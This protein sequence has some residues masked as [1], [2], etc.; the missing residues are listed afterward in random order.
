MPTT[1]FVPSHCIMPACY[2]EVRVCGRIEGL[3]QDNRKRPQ[4]VTGLQN[5][6]KWQKQKDAFVLHVNDGHYNDYT[7][8]LENWHLPVPVCVLPQDKQ[9]RTKPKKKKSQ[10][11][12]QCT[13]LSFSFTQG[14]F[15][16]KRS[17][18]AKAQFQ[19]KMSILSSVTEEDTPVNY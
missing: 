7:T 2:L 11:A 10:L 19:V 6:V 4:S 8:L 16:Y 18:G 13:P 12:L 9:N 15:H 14:R 17:T 1:A 3:C 5:P